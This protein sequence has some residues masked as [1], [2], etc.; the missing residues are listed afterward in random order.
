MN[1]DSDSIK[2]KRVLKW[3]WDNPHTSFYRDKYKKAGFLSWKQIK[4]M[5]DFKKLPFLT[6][7]DIVSNNPYERCFLPL[8]RITSV[9]ISGGTTDS[10]NPMINFHTRLH[11]YQIHH[12]SKKLK[13]LKIKAMLLLFAHL[14]TQGRILREWNEIKNKD[15]VVIAGDTNNLPITSKLAKQL[16]IDAL[17]TTPTIL[18]FLIP[19]LQKEYDL[20]K[21]RY[22]FLMGEFCSEVKVDYFKKVFKNAYFQSNYG[23]NETSMRGFRCDFL[24]KLPPRF[25]HPLPIFHFEIHN[26]DEESEL[27]LTHLYTKV[28]FPFIRY[29]TGDCVKI[30]DKKCE[31]GQTKLMEVFGKLEYDVARIHG[32]TLY[33]ENIYKA[34]SLFS[35]YLSSLDFQIHVFEKVIGNKILPQFILHVVPKSSALK[36]WPQVKNLIAKGISHNLYLSAKMTLSQLV[37]NKVFLPLEIESVK[38]LPIIGKRK[39]IISHMT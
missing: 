9:R 35:K 32:T 31:C 14:Q 11:P 39:H 8:E 17:R 23:G 15:T 36:T 26:P 21:I 5:E 28:A 33:A 38:A 18:Y 30:E 19:Y 20:N 10:Q 22:I 16:E 24:A 25:F 12:F 27:I 1:K 34:L 29:K 3:A 13:Q 2:I 7:Q 6:R 4:S 37:E